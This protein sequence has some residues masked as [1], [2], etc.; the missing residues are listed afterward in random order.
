MFR[1]PNFLC[2]GTMNFR[3]VAHSN[4]LLYKKFIDKHPDIYTYI[5]CENKE[6][7]RHLKMIQSQDTLDGKTQND[8]DDLTNCYAETESHNIIQESPNNID[9]I[10]DGY[11]QDQNG[12]AQRK[13]VNKMDEYILDM[14]HYRIF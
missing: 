12:L 5:D 11:T 10:L 9:M 13:Y 14:L 3:E 6:N 2:E 4:K 1:D 7:Q 8:H